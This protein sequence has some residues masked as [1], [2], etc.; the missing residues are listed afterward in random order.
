MKGRLSLV[1]IAVFVVFAASGSATVFPETIALPDGFRPEG[2]SIGNGT[3]FYVGSIPTGAIYAG[4]LRTGEGSVFIAG[5]TGRAAIGVEFDRGL[6]YVAGGPTGKAF[7][8][9]ADSGELVREIQLASGA[10][11]TF[12]ND[13]V[14]TRDAAYFTESRQA[15][16]YRVPLAQD[17][18]PGTT[19]E[20][21]PV[22]GDFVLVPDVTNL[23]GIVATPDGSTLVVVQ[24][25]TGLIFRVDPLTGVATEIELGGTTLPNGDGLLLV[26]RTLYVVQNR[27]NQIAV[28]TLDPELGSGVVG[29]TITDPDFDVPTT[30]DRLGDQLYAVNARFGVLS[31]DTATYSVVQADR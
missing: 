24:S 17:G 31:P 27:L 13:V 20:V 25:P 28:V 4:D 26:G 29:R 11:A 1:S 3:T 15:V 9:D 10:G 7:V 22:T 8:Y 12:V 21:V 19:A 14:V 23:N 16:L 6:L 18:T 30:I 2:I 5:A